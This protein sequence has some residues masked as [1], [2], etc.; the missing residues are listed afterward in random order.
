MNNITEY[1][2]SS[3]VETI[4]KS[5]GYWMVTFVRATVC[6]CYALTEVS[7]MKRVAYWFLHLRVVH[8]S[9]R[10]FTVIFWVAGAFIRT[11][12]AQQLPV[13]A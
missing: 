1:T 7:I 6:L 3:G 10:S 8:K 11:W 12:T 13:T 5:I 9:A 2:G 4:E